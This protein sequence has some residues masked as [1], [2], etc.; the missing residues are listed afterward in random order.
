MIVIRIA[1]PQATTQ[2]AVS[3]ILTRQKTGQF[4]KC[5]FVD[6]TLEFAGCAY[7]LAFMSPALGD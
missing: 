4:C 2:I 3:V 7:G 1:V 6:A 5:H